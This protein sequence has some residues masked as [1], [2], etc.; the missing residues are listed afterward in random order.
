[1]PLP[2]RAIGIIGPIYSG[3]SIVAKIATNV[4]D[5]QGFSHSTLLMEIAKQNSVE[6]IERNTLFN[7]YKNLYYGEGSDIMAR[8]TLEMVGPEF[9][10]VDGIR[11]PD[12]AEYY[13]REA[14]AFLIAV[15]VSIDRNRENS[16]KIR[17]ER[18]LV[19]PRYGDKIEEFDSRDALEWGEVDEVY[20]LEEAMKRAHI[21]L[22]ND[23][24]EE[25]FIRYLKEILLEKTYLF[26]KKT[27]R[28]R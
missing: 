28:F 25:D 20:N 1:M 15:D 12:E 4:L 22:T 10:L 14:N 24:T 11:N 19:N 7:I 23:R 17:R 13:R 18:A 27:D 21:H 9:F 16:V 26:W 5:Y 2:Y 3:K 6:Q 8:K